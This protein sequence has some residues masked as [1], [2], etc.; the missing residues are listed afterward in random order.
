[1]ILETLKGF[2]VATQLETPIGFPRVRC[3]HAQR[4]IFKVQKLLVKT[5]KPFIVN[6]VN[7]IP[8]PW[9]EPLLI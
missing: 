2:P 9:T 6:H 3:L 7:M 4:T 5:K 8:C 1:M